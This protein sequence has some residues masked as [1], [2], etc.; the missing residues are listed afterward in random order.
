MTVNATLMIVIASMN[1]PY[2]IKDTHILP[3]SLYNGRMDTNKHRT[4][5]EFSCQG[6]QKVFKRRTDKR[7][8]SPYCRPCRG[9]IT[10]TKHNESYS[11]VYKIWQGMRQRCQ[12]SNYSR[13]KDYGG[14][15]IKVCE[16]WNNYVNFSNW[17]KQSNYQNGLTIER[18][19][20]NGNYCPEN[21]TWIPLGQQAL[22]RTNSIHRLQNQ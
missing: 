1:I 8:Q 20:V 15:G 14:R 10:L 6:C 9:R 2:S 4:Y 17:V 16:E 5:F 21:C 7:S 11:R 18:I 3:Q 22:N 19:D 13:Y 12:N